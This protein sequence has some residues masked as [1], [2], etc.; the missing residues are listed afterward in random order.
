MGSAS[1]NII[2]FGETGAGKSSVVNMLDGDGVEAEVSSS[3]KAVTFD[4]K[5]YQKTIKHSPFTV[6][7]TVGLSNDSPKAI[8]SQSA[9]QGLSQLV[10]KLEDGVSLLVYVMRGLRITECAQRNYEMFYTQLCQ[11]RVPIVIVITGLENEQ[12]M[13][14]WWSKNKPEF[15]KHKM[16]FN[17]SACITASKLKVTLPHR[18]SRNPYGIPMDSVWIPYPVYGIRVDSL[19]SP[20]NLYGICTDSLPSPYSVHGIRMESVRTPYS[21]H[22][23]CAE[24]IWTPYSVH[25]IHKDS[26]SIPWNP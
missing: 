19:R 23:I 1:P 3:A 11:G 26:L 25:G 4:S 10:H 24:S 22:G 16:K 21:F 17:K 6:F 13:D 2:V 9:F 8:D 14:D 5:Q 12:N 20:R 15:D 18:S 7:D